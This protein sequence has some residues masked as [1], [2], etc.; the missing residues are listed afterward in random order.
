[1]II[2]LTTLALVGCSDPPE[3]S[4]PTEA[5]ASPATCVVCTGVEEEDIAA[6]EERVGALEDQLDRIQGGLEEAN[7]RLA[8]LEDTQPTPPAVVVSEY[9]VD[10]VADRDPGAQTEYL[11]GYPLASSSGETSPY[12]CLIANIDITDPPYSIAAYWISDNSLTY[13]SYSPELSMQLYGFDWPAGFDSLTNFGNDLRYE[14]LGAGGLPRTY[15]T[16][17]GDVYSATAPFQTDW[18]AAPE[19]LPEKAIPVRVVIIHDR[20]YSLPTYTP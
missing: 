15:V 11:R 14:F 18:S 7:A 13:P 16:P 3:D 19:E 2:L 17:T 5:S 8:A 12:L 4:Q 1:M 10:C 20:P 6:L 9:T